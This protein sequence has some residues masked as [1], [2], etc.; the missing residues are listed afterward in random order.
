MQVNLATAAGVSRPADNGRTAPL[1]DLFQLLE[2]SSAAQVRHE[3]DLERC[4]EKRRRKESEHQQVAASASLAPRP[5]ELMLKAEREMAPGSHAAR[6]QQSHSQLQ[7]Q[8]SQRPPGFRQALTDAASHSAGERP[9]ATARTRAAGAPGGES[10]TA[11]PGGAENGKSAQPAEPG[12]NSPGASP[13]RPGAGAGPPMPSGGPRLPAVRPA[14]S[15]PLPAYHLAGASQTASRGL[16]MASAAASARPGAT[17]SSGARAPS[18]T[19]VA[20]ATARAGAAGGKTA[21]RPTAPAE[22]EPRSSD[23]N[24]ERILR[25]IHT[26]VGKERS[27]AALRLEPPELGTIRLR[28]DLRNEQLSLQIETQTVAARQLLTEH[29]ESLRRS[30]EASGIHLERVEI[31]APAASTDASDADNSPQAGAWTGAEESSGRSDAE[32]AG[33][34]LSGETEF[35]SMEP[36]ELPGGAVFPEPVAES[37]VNVLA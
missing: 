21:A 10:K 20:A 6:A 28:M 3:Q 32:S 18:G 9:P 31:R 2:P 15:S 23:A 17:N 30:L 19:P 5:S 1:P 11:A 4:A 13:A 37:L 14:A 36:S 8:V 22:P 26:R 34:G 27:V 33:G 7:E 16:A 29:V 35:P 24:L 12:A 25:F